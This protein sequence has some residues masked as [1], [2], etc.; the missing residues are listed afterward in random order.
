MNKVMIMAGGTGGHVFPALAVADELRAHGVDIVWLGTQRGLEARVVPA[1]GYAMEWIS[2]RGVRGTGA[3]GWL[4]LPVRLLVALI[5]AWGILRRC[6]PDAVLAMGGFVSGPG[7]LVARLL[8]RPLV[9]HEQNA[10]A[11]MTNRWLAYIASGVMCGFPEAFADVPGARHVGNPVR[12][13][14][15][16]LPLPA[17]RLANRR[18][19]LRVL[20]VG[21]SL[22]AEVFN[23]IVPQAVR[24]LPTASRPEVWHQTGRNK[25]DATERAYDK[26]AVTTIVTEFIDDMATAYN[27]ADLVICRAGA[28]TIAELSAAGAA[29]ILVPYPHAV[30]DHQS[31]NARFLVS[32]DAAVLVPQG[33][34]TVTRLAELLQS[35][36]GNRALVLTMAVNAR[37]CAVPDAAESVAR[38]CL[39]VMHA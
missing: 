34:F 2:I 32:R 23:Q 22:G 28:M 20:I 18:G 9:I 6:R 16:A 25:R 1:A 15:L 21:G 19:R 36:T 10:I 27:W 8:G 3:I 33:D 11:G 4:L 30:D 39:E 14:I 37:S 17:E 31:A 35:F 38:A 12:K 5:Q 7:G 13:E 29:A 26:G 24:A